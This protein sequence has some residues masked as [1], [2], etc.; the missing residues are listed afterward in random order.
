MKKFCKGCLLTGAI[1]FGLLIVGSFALYLFWQSP[2]KI[3]FSDSPIKN[4]KYLNLLSF[5]NRQL[6]NFILEQNERDILYQAFIKEDGLDM[7]VIYKVVIRLNKGIELP[8]SLPFKLTEKEEINNK[9]AFNKIDDNGFNPQIKIPE[10]EKTQGGRHLTVFSPQNQ[11]FMPLKNGGY[12]YSRDEIDK[13]G[14][15]TDI[16]IYDKESKLLYFERQRYYAFQ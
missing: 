13:D 16:I 3:E 1:L 8:N 11:I 7:T 9:I 15:V 14:Y 12:S 5:E 10:D 6:P 4:E 2:K